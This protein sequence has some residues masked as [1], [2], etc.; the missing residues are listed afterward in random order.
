MFKKRKLT[1]NFMSLSVLPLLAFD[2]VITIIMSFVAYD[3]LS[4]EVEYSLK[5]LAYSSYN[6][7]DTKFPGTYA[8][9][10]GR[11]KKGDVFLDEHI[12][13]MDRIKKMSEADA[14]LF[15]GDTRYLT[16]I[17]NEDGKRAKGTHASAAV[18]QQ[19]IK[20]GEDYFS[21]DVQ[22]NGMQYYGYYIPVKQQQDVVGM[23]FVGKPR[24]QVI[25][26]IVKTIYVIIACAV[27]VMAVAILISVYYSRKTIFALNKTKVFLGN[28]AQGDMTAKIDPYVLERND[29]IGEM[30][31]FALILQDSIME[32][33]GKDP[34]TGLHNR[35]SCN[36]VIDSLLEKAKQGHGTFALA[37]G[38]IDYFKKINDTYG[39]IQGDEV[40]RQV[41]NVMDQFK[42]HGIIARFGGEEFILLI[43]NVSQQELYQ[44]AEH[45]RYTCE[46][47][48]V[49]CGDNQITFTISIGC[50]HQ[51]QINTTLKA[52]FEE[53]DQR[54]YVA[55]RN[56]KNCVQM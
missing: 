10:N 14:T 37:M 18:K 39:H 7:L 13:E 2:V 9:E 24:H 35:R 52:I 15:F 1:I 45:I 50:C 29:E 53:A 33:V 21:D 36:V 51:T 27:G 16:T 49:K 25:A 17:L 4:E 30:G 54:L 56:G 5:V 48:I 38:D 34:L 42:Q 44:I 32:L 22:V 23:M 6:V 8:E 26:H 46:S 43:N 31:K 19:V 47:C 40:I 11:M 55:K 12:D 20:Q 41:T 3:S 28:I